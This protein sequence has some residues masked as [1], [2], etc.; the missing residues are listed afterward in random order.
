MNRLFLIL[1]GLVVL[2]FPS[3]SS[4]HTDLETSSPYAGQVV[5]EK[6]EKI[7]LTFGG[8]IESLSSMKLMSEGQEVS[9]K[10]V[11]PN[12]NQLIGTLESPLS[13]GSYLIQWDIAGEDGHLIEGEIP[14]VVEMA[15]VKDESSEK[16]LIEENEGEGSQGVSREED[17]PAEKNSSSSLP[18]SVR[19][20]IP[21]IALL[22]LGPGLILLFG[23]KKK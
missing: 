2:T 4:A 20:L 12:E 15:S 21:I 19:T 6:L 18:F 3:K 17:R 13:N 10:S 7:E 22:I 9:L 8:D 14:F 5:T 16:P 11:I 23:R 1:I